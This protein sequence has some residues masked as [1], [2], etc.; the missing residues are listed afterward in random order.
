MTTPVMKG[1]F[2]T[3]EGKQEIENMIA[4]LEKVKDNSEICHEWNQADIEQNVYKEI[5]SSATII[6]EPLTSNQ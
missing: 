2:L 4:E 1:I 6:A 3:P 5:L